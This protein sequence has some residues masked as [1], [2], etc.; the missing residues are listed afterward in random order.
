MAD[1]PTDML[2]LPIE[3]RALGPILSMR[4]RQD[5]E[6]PYMTVDGRTYSFAETDRI[7]RQ[8]GRGMRELGMRKQ[9][10][11][12][13]LLPNG[14]G[15]V[16]AWYAC[17]VIGAVFVPINPTYTGYML[18][19]IL[20][21]SGTRGLFVHASLLPQLATV[22]QET[23]SALEWVAVVG[24]TPAA[25]LPVGPAR[26]LAFEDVLVDGNDD[27]EVPC[28]F[29]DLQSVMYTSGTTG[30]SKGV[31]LPNGHFFSSSGVFLRALHLTR[32][33]ILFTPLPL[34]H[35]LAS[36]LGVLPA[37][38]IGA[39]VVI[40]EKFSASQF[41]RQV[42]ECGATVAHTIFTLPPMLKAQ[43]PSPWDR[44]HK[45]RAMYNANFDP[46]FE[47]RFNVRLVEAYGLTETGLTIYTH[48]PERRDGSCGKAHE[49]WEIEVVDDN[50]FPVATGEIGELVCRP[51]L[52]S[53]MMQGYLNKPDETLRT[54]RD[55]WFHCGDYA[56]RDADGYFYFSG[57]KKE[58]I[59]RHG[60]N[61]SGFEVECIVGMH[62]DISEV[63]AVAHPA[64]AGEDDVRCVI[65]LRTGAS[66][67]EVEL[68][69]WLQPRMP[70]FMLPR[71][72]EF[73]AEMPRTPS[74]K[75]EKYKLV[76][77]GLS[78]SAW[79]REKAGCKIERDSA[80]TKA[81]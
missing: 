39:Q 61:I 44:A 71:Y 57:R 78:A 27:P 15:F 50:G 62:P 4:A 76:E 17:C 80:K 49:D 58:R 2:N 81:T 43:P 19:Y 72:I 79:D 55:L 46:D 24:D 1:L 37:M 51:K 77:A 38:M 63:A 69:D 30:P 48:W 41:W 33:D 28:T 54:T 8:L 34:F 67:S 29:R 25:A 75:I 68:M 70:Y 11:V 74:E 47:A 59:R 13:M 73:V 26:Y 21:D 12:T 36:R 64:E 22:P 6:R 52:P 65:I 31:M 56:R 42:T 66:L 7:V 45:L 18:D 5:G 14:A 60:E 35:G 3:Q 10:M 53:I 32:D 23:L 40:A 9:D 16:F 20:K